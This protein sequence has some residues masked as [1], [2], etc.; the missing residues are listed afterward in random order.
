MFCGR[1]G[2]N[3]PDGFAYCQK[4]GFALNVGINANMGMSD[5]NS[6]YNANQVTNNANESYNAN[7]G[8]G[9]MNSGYNA[10]QGMGNMNGG[11]TSKP[12]PNPWD[13]N[14]DE[15]NK[16]NPR[17]KKNIIIVAS[18]VAAIAIAL[19]IILP[20]TLCDGSDSDERKYGKPTGAE[21]V[22]EMA[23]DSIRD[24]DYAKYESL[25]AVD[26]KDEMLSE[27]IFSQRNEGLQDVTY[28][29]IEK[30]Q[31]SDKQLED[32]N[33]EY[34]VN[35]S[36]AWSYKLDAHFDYEDDDMNGDST[37]RV[38]VYK[39]AESENWYMIAHS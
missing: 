12:S 25:F 35:A 7:Q 11:F 24:N 29:V 36:E 20:L 18:I 33:E 1:C 23:V 21:E 32:F 26:A 13:F 10:N 6:G 19:A 5:M 27:K 9:N 37:V 30:E 16:T 17:K 22:V 2:A 31:A 38:D 15:N 3:N 39:D 34:G 4:C 28:E 14:P 8:V